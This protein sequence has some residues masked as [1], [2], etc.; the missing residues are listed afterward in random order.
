MQTTCRERERE[1]ETDRQTDRLTDTERFVGKLVS[2][3][4]LL[5]II[6]NPQR[7]GCTPVATPCVAEPVVE[8]LFL[9]K[10]GDPGT[11]RKDTSHKWLE[12]LHPSTI[13][14]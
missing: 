2:F 13:P 11:K 3:S 5:K 8:S 7:D 9:N 14:P 12:T 10:L 4:Y 6:R 1:K